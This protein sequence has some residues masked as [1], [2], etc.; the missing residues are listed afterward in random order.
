MFVNAIT[1]T[2]RVTKILAHLGLPAIALHA[3][4][5]QRQRLKVRPQPRPSS[6]ARVITR[7]PI[8]KRSAPSAH[9]AAQQS[10]RRLPSLVVRAPLWRSD[11]PC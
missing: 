9:V 3:G 11:C 1:M 2:L 8:P 7:S 10:L 5:Q 4:Q 6:S